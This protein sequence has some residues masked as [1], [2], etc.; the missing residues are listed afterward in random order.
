MTNENRNRKG[1]KYRSLAKGEAREH[2]LNMLKK[3]ELFFP[4]VAKLNDPYETA[5]PI[6]FKD[7]DIIFEKFSHDETYNS[8]IYKELCETYNYFRTENSGLL[9]LSLENT[10]FLMWSHYADGHKGICVGIDLY[11]LV[12]EINSN[13]QEIDYIQ[14][15]KKID[16]TKDILEGFS[17]LM[18]VKAEDWIYEKECRILSTKYV[19]KTYCAKQHIKEVILGANI[20]EKDEKEVLAIVNEYIPNCKVYKVRLSNIK[21]KLELDKIK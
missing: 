2:T 14:E 18:F 11:N 16:S 8:P 6:I 12:T 4:S 21:F 15:F 20:S 5:M 10:I 9:C 17:S 3:G 1:Y 19:N 7:K 13:I